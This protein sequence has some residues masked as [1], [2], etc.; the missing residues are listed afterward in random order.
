M[1]AIPTDVKWHLIVVLICGNF[2]I[3][4]FAAAFKNGVYLFVDMQRATVW[5]VVRD[6]GFEITQIWVQIPA[7]S[8]V[9]CV[10]WVS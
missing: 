6:M 3:R 1:T 4:Q 2:Y 5:L 7:R 9:G 10:P 8:L